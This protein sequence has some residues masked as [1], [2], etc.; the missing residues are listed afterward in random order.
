M[1]LVIVVEFL[2]FMYWCLH[3]VNFWMC[4]LTDIW[5][6][7]INLILVKGNLDLYFP[8]GKQIHLRLQIY[9]D[10][11]SNSNYASDKPRFI[12]HNGNELV[13]RV[14]IKAIFLVIVVQSMTQN[15]FVRSTQ[16]HYLLNFGFHDYCEKLCL[17][18]RRDT[19]KKWIFHCKWMIQLTKLVIWNQ[20]IW[21]HWL[22][23]RY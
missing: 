19:I 2:L 5:Q 8:L 7:K 1:N 23:N 20:G 4:W 17:L 14:I 22:W 16:T 10:F 18:W 9:L 11:P 6:I 21:N 3:T 12:S 15:L 13:W